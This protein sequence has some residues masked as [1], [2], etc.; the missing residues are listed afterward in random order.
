MIT[1]IFHISTNNGGNPED[2]SSHSDND[3]DASGGSVLSDNDDLLD[4]EDLLNVI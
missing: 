2:D 3:G 4:G 1:A